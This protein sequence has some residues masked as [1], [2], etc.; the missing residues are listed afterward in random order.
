VLDTGKI[1]KLCLNEGATEAEVYIVR[2]KSLLVKFSTNIDNIKLTENVGIGL[3][4]AVG[5]RIAVLG[6]TDI[7]DLG[8]S[9]AIRSVVK[10]AK[11]SP[12]DPGWVSLPSTLNKSP[13]SGTY[14]RK[15]ANATV[16]E[17]I[18]RVRLSMEAV[19]IGSMYSRPVRGLLNIST[20][21]VIIENSYSGPIERSETI[22]GFY[23]NARSDYGGKTATFSKSRIERSL[24]QIPFEDLG[25]EAGEKAWEFTQAKGIKT[26]KYNLLINAETMA[27][28][29]DVMLSQVISA[30]AVQKGRSP[31]GDKLGKQV[32]T[33]LLTVIDDGLNGYRIGGREFDDEGIP[34][35]RTV[36]IDKGVL[37]SFLYDTYT[38]NK[39]GRESTGNAWRTLST[40][41]RP[42]PNRLVV[43]EGS[44]SLDELLNETRNG[45]YVVS[46]IGEWLSNPISGSLNATITHAYIVKDGD[47]I[48]TGKGAVV[49]ADFYD[50]M[51]S[52]LVLIGKDVFNSWKV[53]APSMLFSNIQ[54]AG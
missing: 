40:T 16:D 19:R 3:R 9:E 46:T 54:I 1:V 26:G 12:E 14:D 48:A 6:V 50:I 23:I 13:V 22:V 53:T 4:V 29:I 20:E 51:K 7:S 41:P 38:A 32:F 27:S 24:D 31:L 25:K 47:V 39:E 21:K 44:A 10:I 18:E 49:S 34:T 8:I 43:Q 17:S 52:K 28:I 36:V 5:K 11:I 30:E 15:T 35:K 2:K 33:E 45:L 37:K 42:V